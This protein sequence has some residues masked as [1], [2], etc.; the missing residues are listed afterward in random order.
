VRNTVVFS[1]VSFC[2]M[3]G[4]ADRKFI[5]RDYL[6]YILKLMRRD[7]DP[8][9]NLTTHSTFASNQNNLLP[10][11]PKPAGI[12]LYTIYS[13]CKPPGRIRPPNSRN[14]IVFS[15]M[16]PNPRSSA[17]LADY[18][19]F[20]GDR[21]SS[22]TPDRLRCHYNSC[23]PWSIREIPHTPQNLRSYNLIT[24]ILDFAT[25]FSC[26]FSGEKG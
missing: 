9:K 4:F 8:P 12:N 15:G 16:S 22:H 23:K 20:P 1:A 2:W 7:L 18:S 6:Q 11:K 17:W 24:A 19:R 21:L 5:K 3:Y 13:S 14:F 10:F 26:F 25:P